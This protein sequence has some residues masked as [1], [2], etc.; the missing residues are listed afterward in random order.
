MHDQPSTPNGSQRRTLLVVGSNPPTTSGQRTLGRAELARVALGFEHV[1]LENL[2]SRPTYRTGG[3]SL[4]GIT[5]VGWQEARP[6]L[7]AALDRAAAVLMAYGTT[8]PSG[9]AAQH[10]AEQVI[11]IERQASER[12]LDVWT[13][14]GAPRH[15]SRW[16]R[17]TYRE[18]PGVPF[19]DAL[20]ASLAIQDP[21]TSERA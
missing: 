21:A 2:F 10:F 20:R 17:Y 11:W 12:G 15:P 6:L 1:E 4:A 9:A 13:V 14:G 7:L 18:H 16:Q 8:K 3:V 5:D 19:P